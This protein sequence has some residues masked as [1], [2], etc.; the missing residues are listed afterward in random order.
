MAGALVFFSPRRRVRSGNVGGVT[1]NGA[2]RE[3]RL[4]VRHIVISEAQVVAL[5]ESFHFSKA[6]RRTRLEAILSGKE[7]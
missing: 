2:N 5:A 6:K 3:A 1:P 4:L 7:R